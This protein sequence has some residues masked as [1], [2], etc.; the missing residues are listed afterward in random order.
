MPPKAPARPAAS[1]AKTAAAP[2]AST[3]KTA[4]PAAAPA[5]TPAAAPAAAAAPAPT[6]VVA[7]PPPEPVKK[8]PVKQNSNVFNMFEKKQ[9]QEFKEAFGLWDQDRDGVI[10]VDDLREVYS[11]L[12]KVPKDNDLKEMLTEAAGPM[13]FTMMLSLFADNMGGTDEESTILNAFK[14]YDP[15]AKGNLH[16][17]ALRGI[18]CSEGHP[19]ERLTDKEFNQMLEGAPMDQ[20]GNL[21]YAAFT[22]LVKRGKDEDE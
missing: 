20:K 15:E 14:L 11:N 17:E 8:R 3:A 19:N 13:N 4:T 10:S 5:A 9:V 16:R 7:A 12:G 1:T 22:K 18:L 2:A 21:D 6:P